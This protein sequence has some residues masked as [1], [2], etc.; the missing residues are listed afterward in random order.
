MATLAWMGAG[1]TSGDYSVAA[2]WSTA[3]TPLAGDDVRIPP[4]S[5][6]AISAGLNQSGVAIGDFIVERGYNQ[7]IGTD[8]TTSALPVYLRVDPNR[9][10]YAGGGLAYLD[11]GSA[12][13][14]A[15]VT[16]TQS[17]IVGKSGLYLKGSN[18]SELSVNSGAVGVAA[19]ATE[20]STVATATVNGA[21][22][23][24][25][26]GEGVSLTTARCYDGT[27]NLRCSATTL[28]VYGGTVN[29]EEV[30]AVTNLYMW[31]GTVNYTSNANMTN[32]YLYDGTLDTT[33]AGVSRTLTTLYHYDGG[34]LI[35]DRDVMTVTNYTPS[36]GRRVQVSIREV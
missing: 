11:L 33:A 21:G 18:I 36:S 14:D 5:T 20:T 26:L 3:A 32:A 2:N 22:A 8:A 34:T 19:V 29:I 24:L 27:M 25:T 6:V 35:Y 23:R 7:Q 31:G 4:T 13:I 9:F 10:E 30:S 12:A 28:E 16:Y 17:A 15:V 1:G